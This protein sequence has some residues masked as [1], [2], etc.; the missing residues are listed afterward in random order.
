LRKGG[1]GA[2]LDVKSKLD[3]GQRPEGIDPW[4]L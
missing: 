1:K 2:V 3:R 4:H